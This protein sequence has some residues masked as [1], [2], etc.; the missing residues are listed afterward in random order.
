M[1]LPTTQWPKET[2]LPGFK[3]TVLRYLDQVQKLSY[4]FI[5]LIAEALGLQPDGLARFYD[6]DEFMQHRSKVR[7][8]CFLYT[9]RIDSV[10]L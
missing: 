8:P 10:F 1:T 7:I 2:E 6:T 3:E 4:E 9:L 5:S